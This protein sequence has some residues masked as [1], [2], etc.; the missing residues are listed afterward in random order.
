MLGTSLDNA[1]DEPLGCGN[2]ATF[3]LHRFDDDCSSFFGC[4]LRLEQVVE[5]RKRTVDS[6][7]VLFRGHGSDIRKWCDK[8]ATG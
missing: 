1:L 7:V 5:P 2:V 3:A 4:S 8:N 6:S